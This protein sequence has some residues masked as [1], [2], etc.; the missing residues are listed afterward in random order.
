MKEAIELSQKTWKTQDGILMTDYSSQAPNERFGKHAA[1][2]D[3]D[4]FREF[5][6]ETRDHDF[7]IMLEIKDKEKSA[8]KAIE[9]VKNS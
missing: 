5:L 8:L 6:K 2:V 3:V 4:N 7:D 9:V 1:S